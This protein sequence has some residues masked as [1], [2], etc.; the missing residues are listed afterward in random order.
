MTA[1]MAY[2]V[3]AVLLLLFAAMHTV[4][5]LTFTPPTAEGMAVRD[6][7]TSVKFEI[8]GVN[9]SYASFY[10]GFG[11]SVTAYLLFSAYLAWCLSK[12]AVARLSDIHALAWAFVG[13]QLVCLV[14]IVAYFFLLPAL[15]SAAIVI[16]LTW[17]AWSLPK[18]KA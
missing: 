7:M 6:A 9:A 4:G 10:I 2:R 18:A 16:C 12:S 8:R 13:V 3:A 11:L 17:A 15:F 5:F 1:T 14:L